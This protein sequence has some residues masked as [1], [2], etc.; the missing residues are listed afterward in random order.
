MQHHDW[1]VGLANSLSLSS[2][3]VVRFWCEVVKSTAS[4]TF[5]MYAL[6]REIDGGLSADTHGV[7]FNFSA[8]NFF[9][10]IDINSPPHERLN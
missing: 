5:G 4:R 9:H 2:F 1:T 3:G 8:I 6:R 7:Q 10:A